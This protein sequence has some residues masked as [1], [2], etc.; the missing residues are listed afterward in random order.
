MKVTNP[1]S[2]AEEQIPKSH[3]TRNR[4]LMQKQKVEN[5]LQFYILSMEEKK[6][7]YIC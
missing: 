3:S 2:G 6:Y 1:N 4:P 7:S 5:H